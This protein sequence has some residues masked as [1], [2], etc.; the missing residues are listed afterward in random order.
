M[1]NDVS[2]I[3]CHHG[4][5]I[6]DMAS[7]SKVIVNRFLEKYSSKKLYQFSFDLE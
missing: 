7:A 2:F 5:T 6:T 1:S 4:L 3:F